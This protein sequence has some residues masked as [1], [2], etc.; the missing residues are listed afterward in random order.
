MTDREIMRQAE[1]K[2]TG[3]IDLL[4]TGQ[5]VNF[6]EMRKKLVEV[7]GDIHKVT[8]S[9]ID[10]QVVVDNLDDN[11]LIANS[12]EEI[13]YVNPAYEKH[14]GIAKEALI[15]HKVSNVLKTQ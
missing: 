4:S 3:L 15:G 14:T 5:P 13:L 7:R 12:Q 1:R 10:Y 11:I 9:D 2:V 8:S 6:Q